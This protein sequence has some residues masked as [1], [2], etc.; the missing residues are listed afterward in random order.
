MDKPKK[1]LFDLRGE[2]KTQ[3]ILRK[4]HPGEVVQFVRDA[5]NTHDPNAIRIHNASGAFLGWIAREDAADLAPLLDAGEHC[6]VRVHQLRGGISDY[7]SYGCR[8]SIQ[9]P[10]EKDRAPKPLDAEQL[11]F[12]SKRP[13]GCS[14]LA[15]AAMVCVLAGWQ[16]LA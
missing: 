3:N 13:A 9:W 6:V 2:S 4:T 5:R 12:R 11:A 10:S 8:I 1:R 15:G 16:L 7:P 14:A